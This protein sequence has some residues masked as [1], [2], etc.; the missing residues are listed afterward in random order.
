MGGIVWF[1]IGKTYSRDD[2]TLL[3]LFYDD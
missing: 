3:P 2:T 1:T